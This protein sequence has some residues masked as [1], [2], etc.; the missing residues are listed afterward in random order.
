M[1]TKSGRFAERIGQLHDWLCQWLFHL[2][3]TILF[4]LALAISY[5]VVVRY[6]FNRPTAW[7]VDF[8]EYT[9]IYSTFLAAPWLFKI[10]GHTSITAMVDLLGGRSRLFAGCL[11]SLIGILVCTI[12]AY[13]GI[14]DTWDAYREHEM[15]IR[16]II[17]PKFAIL[18]VIPFGAVLLFMYYFRQLLSILKS[19]KG[20]S[21]F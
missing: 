1:S 10:R 14:S 16:P 8:S 6:F 18:W 5:E 2:G 13:I 9:L 21:L 15:I 19:L 7:A 3:A 4:G 20:H 17:I 11:S 12:L